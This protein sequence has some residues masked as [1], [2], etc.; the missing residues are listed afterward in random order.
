M[1]YFDALNVR[2]SLPN[3][4][5]RTAPCQQETLLR[6][7]TRKWRWIAAA[8][9]TRASR[10]KHAVPKWRKLAYSQKEAE[11]ERLLKQFNDEQMVPPHPQGHRGKPNSQ[12][13]RS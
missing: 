7:L 4:K 9:T 2:L 3:K 8:R 10:G 1:D 5:M 11:F 12:N 13:S 6:K